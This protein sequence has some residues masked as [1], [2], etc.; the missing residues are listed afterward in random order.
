MERTTFQI[1]MERLERITLEKLCPLLIKYFGQFGNT[2]KIMKLEEFIPL[3]E[4]QYII[5]DRLFE[6]E[7][8]LIVNNFQKNYD[9]LHKCDEPPA[10]KIRRV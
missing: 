7:F 10:K 5:S 8:L 3:L 1:Q 6:Q 4:K 9:N 2:L